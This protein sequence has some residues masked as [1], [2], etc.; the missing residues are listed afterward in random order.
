MG[1]LYGFA[2]GSFEE[3]A[4]E[5]ERAF[6]IQFVLHESAWRGGDYYRYQTDSEQII[7]QMNRDDGEIAETAFAAFPVLL[8]VEGDARSQ[9]EVS[10]CLGAKAILLRNRNYG[11]K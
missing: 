5:I 11:P 4:H 9:A 8:Y 3:L 10:R 6:N 7:L 2:E 1:L